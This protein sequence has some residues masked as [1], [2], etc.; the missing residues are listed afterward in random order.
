MR[1]KKTPVSN[2]LARNSRFDYCEEVQSAT[3]GNLLP[4]IIDSLSYN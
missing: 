2:N 4:K 1:H 3:G